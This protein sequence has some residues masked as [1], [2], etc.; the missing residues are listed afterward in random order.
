MTGWKIPMFNRKYIFIHAGFSNVMLV[1]GWV[2]A[3]HFGA[4]KQSQLYGNFGEVSSYS[5]ALFG[6]VIEWPLANKALL[7]KHNE[8]WTR[9]VVNVK[10]QTWG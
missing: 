7:K 9:A 8:L 6:L 4:M 2:N 3:T 10:K 1:F 5:G